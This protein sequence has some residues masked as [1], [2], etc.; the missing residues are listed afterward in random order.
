VDILLQDADYAYIQEGLSPGDRIVTTNLSTVTAG[1]KLR[2]EEQQEPVSDSTKAVSQH[3][4]TSQL[5]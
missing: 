5:Q 1:A 3:S 4:P 2:L